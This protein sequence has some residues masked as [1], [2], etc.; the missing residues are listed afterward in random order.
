MLLYKGRW[1]RWHRSGCT[2]SAISVSGDRYF[3]LQRYRRIA[4]ELKASGM[5]P[6]FMEVE[7]YSS[8]VSIRSRGTEM[9]A[10]GLIG[11]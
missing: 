5:A 2:I 9:S 4:G 11:K 10:G 8:S 6:D 1:S 7:N 3:L